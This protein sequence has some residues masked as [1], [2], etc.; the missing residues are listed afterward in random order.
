MAQ[1][2]FA[3]SLRNNAPDLMAKAKHLLIRVTVKKLIISVWKQPKKLPDDIEA[4]LLRANTAPS[5][6]ERLVC[7]S[8]VYASDP[9]YYRAWPS[10]YNA[11][12]DLIR[13]EPYL[14]YIDE[15][16]DL[17][18][19]KS[20]LELYLNVPK[21]RAVPEAYPASKHNLLK[22]YVYFWLTLAILGLV[23]AASA[24]SS[25]RP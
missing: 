19:I 7:L 22:T 1:Q 21:S 4:W 24:L 8:R 13:R 16:D 9:H 5:L 17:Y 25:W 6:E 11:L 18:R 3:I 10:M 20:G 12:R 23:W 15:T 2:T 14:G